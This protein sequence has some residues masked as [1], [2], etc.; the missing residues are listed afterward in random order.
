MFLWPPALTL[1]VATPIAQLPFEG[2][3]RGFFAGYTLIALP[4][5]V[6]LLAAPGYMAALLADPRWLHGSGIRRSWVR[7]S[8]VLGLA[9][10]AVGIWAGSLMILF[11]PPALV[12]GICCGVVWWRFERAGR[13]LRGG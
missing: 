5:Y 3:P 7:L 9:C 13:A 12:T 8:L 1:I 10:A 4:F 11:A 2:D 6:G